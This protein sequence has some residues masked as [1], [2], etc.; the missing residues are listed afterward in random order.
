M[1]GDDEINLNE[2]KRVVPLN[3]W[4]L[5]SN[6]KLAYNLFRRRYGGSFNREFSEIEGKEVE[7][8]WRRRTPIPNPT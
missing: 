3:T 1:V 4:A 5:I 6:F 8:N 7:R 2:S